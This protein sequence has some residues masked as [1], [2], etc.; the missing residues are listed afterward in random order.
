MVYS[1]K[2]A[3][4]AAVLQAANAMCAAIR[5]APKAKGV[6]SLESCILTGEDIARLA[7]RME[8]LAAERGAGFLLRDAGNM[9]QS[10]AVV[11]VGAQR[12]PRGL[13]GLC[14]YCGFADCKSCTDAGGTCVYAPMDLGIAL[15]S[16]TA[17]AADRRIDTRVFFSAGRAAMDLRVL[18]ETYGC[19]IAIG[20]SVSAKSPYFDR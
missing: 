19:C 18:P 3:E 13:G 12:Q 7:D 15:G 9:R 14:G 16:A 1:S 4:N 2:D 8:A 11:V 20:L 5:T 17:M 10:G 6:D